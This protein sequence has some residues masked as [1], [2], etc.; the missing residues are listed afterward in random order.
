[1]RVSQIYVFAMCRC[2]WFCLPV[3]A[4]ISSQP[5]QQGFRA[6]RWGSFQQKSL[7]VSPNDVLFESWWFFSERQ[8]KGNSWCGKSRSRAAGRRGGLSRCGGWSIIYSQRYRGGWRAR[9]E[10]PAGPE[11]D[12]K[13]FCTLIMWDFIRFYRNGMLH[14]NEGN[15]L[16]LLFF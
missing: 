12:G 13:M 15:F 7:G 16:F 11:K 5:C 2:T 4:L 8:I 10:K 9:D 14:Y 3:L 1:M 6:E